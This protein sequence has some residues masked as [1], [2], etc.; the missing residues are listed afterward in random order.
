MPIENI[1][2]NEGGIQKVTVIE[3]GVK[4]VVREPEFRIVTVGIQGPSGPQGIQGIQG[5]PGI[6]GQDG[7]GDLSFIHNQLVPSNV[8]V[9]T[10]NLGKR[11]SV[12][13]ID[14]GDTEVIGHVTDTDNNSLTVEFSAPFGGKAYLN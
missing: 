13:V 6:Q 7:S 3:G 10:H 1:T 14:S 2:I 4:I 5:E 11:P 9:I 8:W 12:R